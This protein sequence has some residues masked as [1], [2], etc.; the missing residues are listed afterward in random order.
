MVSR[1]APRSEDASVGLAAAILGFSSV[2]V[3]CKRPGHRS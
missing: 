2:I 3:E 1:S